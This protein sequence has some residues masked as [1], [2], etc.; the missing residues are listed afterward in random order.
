MIAAAMAGDL[1]TILVLQYGGLGAEPEPSPEVD[2]FGMSPL[3]WAAVRGHTAVVE[4]L[5][6]CGHDPNLKDEHIGNTAL[7]GACR[8][9]HTA[10]AKALLSAKA[11]ANL[12]NR[13]GLTPLMAAAAAR[14]NAADL[15]MLLLDAGADR[16]A[17]DCR[18]RTATEQAHNMFTEQILLYYEPSNAVPVQPPAPEEGEEGDEK[19]AVDVASRGDSGGEDGDGSP[20]VRFRDAEEDGEPADTE[21]ATAARS[22]PPGKTRRM[23]EPSAKPSTSGGERAASGPPSWYL[24][25]LCRIPGHFNEVRPPRQQSARRGDEVGRD[26]QRRRR[27]GPRRA[28]T[29]G[30]SPG[31]TVVRG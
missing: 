2:E 7:I 17:I 12:S 16:A 14:E 29:G 27:R 25:R 21:A 22:S 9:G 1:E 24:C 10:A 18:G 28:R 6:G 5:A 8:Q 19:E 30:C 20:K 23:W 11:L 31:A 4:H 26:S 13:S 3:M 15:A